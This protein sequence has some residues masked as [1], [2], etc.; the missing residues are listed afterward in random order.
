MTYKVKFSAMTDELI[1]NNSYGQVTNDR[2]FNF[3]Y[4]NP[5]PTPGGLYAEEIFGPEKDYVCGCGEYLRPLE[6]DQ[7]KCS[8][9]HVSWQGYSKLI[10]NSLISFC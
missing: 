2:T 6:G 10:L 1:L 3:K 9:C 4:K 8:V 7:V 5:K